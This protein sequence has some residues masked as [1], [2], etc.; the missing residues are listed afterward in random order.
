MSD[1]GFHFICRRIQRLRWLFSAA[2]AVATAASADAADI[3]LAFRPGPEP[4]V[5]GFTWSQTAAAPLAGYAIPD[6]AWRYA[7]QGSHNLQDW[8]TLTNVTENAS[9]PEEPLAATVAGGTNSHRFYRVAK[10]AWLPNADL[11]GL[12]LAGADFSGANLSR[13]N[14]AGANLAGANFHQANLRSVRFDAAHL[15]GANFREANLSYAILEG[16]AVSLGDLS[17]A[18]LLNTTLPGGRVMTDD[19]VAEML[20]LRHSR[21]ILPDDVLY[22]RV[23]R[24][25][26]SIFRS[27]PELQDPGYLPLL[28]SRLR[29]RAT[30]EQIAALE[31]SPYGPV[32]IFP[33][34]RDGWRPLRF[35][36]H[37]NLD[38]LAELLEAR[39]YAIQVAV[40]RSSPAIGVHREVDLDFTNF[41]Y[42]FVWGDGDCLSGC[43]FWTRW[44]ISTSEG[45]EPVLEEYS[46]T[47]VGP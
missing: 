21:G 15:S 3:H 37:Y 10:I 22:Q 7:L 36:L 27:F 14:L 31:R 18:V 29:I 5:I 24:D 20:V 13:A 26:A 28:P 23:R 34:D 17:E 43:T 25:L 19:D 12:L 9:H 2:L 35:A 39:N 33:L 30:E 1:V 40:L 45:G 11:G 4:G 38:P 46:A 16:T 44:V 41:R 42:T 8:A 32:Q 47:G 6:L